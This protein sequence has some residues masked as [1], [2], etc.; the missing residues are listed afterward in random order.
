[1]QVKLSRGRKEVKLQ[2][3]QRYSSLLDLQKQL[4][5][6]FGKEPWYLDLPE[7][8]GKKAFGNKT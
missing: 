3:K 7:F 5:T 4:A 2:F 6:A 1:M 8:P